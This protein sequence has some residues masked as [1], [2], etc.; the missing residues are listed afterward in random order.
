MPQDV[1][2]AAKVIDFTFQ[3]SASTQPSRFPCPCTYTSALTYSFAK[4]LQVLG[5]ASSSGR[6]FSS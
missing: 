6:T 5:D 3:T 4:T 1:N 2:H